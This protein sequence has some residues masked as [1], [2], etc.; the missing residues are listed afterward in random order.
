MDST[1]IL[2]KLMR[3]FKNGQTA[4]EWFW[5]VISPGFGATETRKE[6][7]PTADLWEANM[8]ITT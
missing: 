4:R 8:T 1:T 6:A 7:R 2:L 5:S 3:H